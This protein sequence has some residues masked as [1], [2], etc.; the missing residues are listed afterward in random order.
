MPKNTDPRANSS[1]WVPGKGNKT[2]GSSIGA[3]WGAAGDT[4]TRNRLHPSSR[5][6]SGAKPRAGGGT[7]GFS[8][9][10]VFSGVCVPIKISLLE[11]GG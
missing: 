11:F 10:G 7:T 9:H 2:P 8:P 1:Q 6:D 3:R 4:R 5:A